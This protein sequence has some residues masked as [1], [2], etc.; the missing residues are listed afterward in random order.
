MNAIVGLS[1][2]LRR[3]ASPEQLDRL[4][5]IDAASQRL[6]SVITDIL[7]V[8]RTEAGLLVPEQA[9]FSLAAQLETD[10]RAV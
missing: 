1:H 6:L 8:S 3:A 4:V 5:K 9:D 10:T 7:D 2:L